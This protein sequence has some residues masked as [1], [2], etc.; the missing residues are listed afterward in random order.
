MDQRH[1]DYILKNIK[2]KPVGEIAR[3]L[4]LRERKV[5][6][7]LKTLKE[8]PAGS[9]RSG[10]LPSAAKPLAAKPLAAKPL[11]AKPFVMMALL[12]A[13]LGFM[14]YGNALQGGFLFDDSYLVTDNVHVKDW[15]HVGK[16]FTEDIGAGAGDTFGFYRPLQALTYMVDYA[17]G[18]LNP[19][20]FHVTSVLWHILAAAGVFAL[21]YILFSDRLLAGITAAL[22]VVHPVH[23]EAVSYISGRSDPLALFFLTLTFVLYLRQLSRPAAYLWVGMTLSYTA[24]LASRETALIF[25]VLLLLYHFVFKKQVRYKE[26]FSFVAL[27]GLYVM[28]RLTL[29]K[30]LLSYVPDMPPLSQ[31][32]PGFFVALASYVRLLVLPFD[33]HME[34]GSRLFSFFDPRA[35]AGLGIFAVLVIVF[36]RLRSRRPLVSFSI[37][38]F[39]IAL[40]PVSN[41][42]PINATMAEHWL[43]MP[44]VGF[45]L[46]VALAVHRLNAQKG[47]RFWG[48]ALLLGLSVF[49]LYLTVRQNETWSRPLTFYTRT[50]RYSPN[51][52]K[53]LNNLGNVYKESGAYEKA[54]GSFRQAVAL[55]PDYREAYNNLGA[56][57]QKMGR[58]EDAV[59]SFKKA[60]E[61]SPGYTVAF[62]NLSAVYQEMGKSD[63]VVASYREI[64]D[65]DPENL[66]ALNNLAV[67]LVNKGAHEE[68]IALYEKAIVLDPDYPDAYNNLG[69]VFEKTGR[70][71]EALA[72]YRKAIALDPDYEDP[73]YN[74]GNVYRKKKMFQEAAVSYK[75]AVTLKPD[76]EAAC[77]NLAAVYQMLGDLKEAVAIYQ[78]IIALHPSAELYYGLGVVHQNAGQRE[79]AVAAYQKAIELK[80]RFVDAYYNAA[81]VYSSMGRHGRAIA[82][83]KK[84]LEIEPEYAMG[85]IHLAVAYYNDRQYA[86]AVENCDK[87]RG[88]GAQVDP[89]FLKALD[90]IK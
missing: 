50:L 47:T 89:G 22:F 55:R 11:A 46:A 68:A 71:E 38:W 21:I 80:P 64:L 45:F 44:S 57:Y 17:I 70:L 12:I 29:L 81:A 7:F 41:I 18:R 36:V 63:E 84:A 10:V 34:Y 31:R 43:Y 88:R 90:T 59:A 83:L 77:I 25:P 39:L 66:Q 65:A 35:L 62:N 51:N 23:T 26:F 54:V 19:V 48:A 33:L 14:A 20:V 73:Y 8:G 86:A 15:S 16:I 3:D 24:A 75:R 40:V 87:G 13:L 60:M 37:G 30:D 56:A 1:K 82:A 79:E 27:A 76:H 5:R 72:S 74:L 69:S 52:P 32:L 4:N 58:L 85:Y 9:R 78:K 28:L 42:F 61:I 67:T 2:V 6:K 49:Y 53:I